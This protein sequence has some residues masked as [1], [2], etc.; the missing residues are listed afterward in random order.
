MAL[1]AVLL[2]F[3]GPSAQ[4][5]AAADGR[6]IGNGIDGSVDRGSETG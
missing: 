3:L 5:I 1:P 6:S 4:F 2:Q